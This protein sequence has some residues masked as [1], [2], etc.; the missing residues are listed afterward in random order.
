MGGKVAG[1]VPVGLKTFF[2]LA[3]DYNRLL[4]LELRNSQSRSLVDEL[5]KTKTYAIPFMSSNQFWTRYGSKTRGSSIA[6][7]F[8]E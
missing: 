2:P 5:I 7:N 1:P 8:S 6:Q 4:L 3:A